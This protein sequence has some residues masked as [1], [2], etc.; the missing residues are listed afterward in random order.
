[1][2]INSNLKSYTKKEKLASHQIKF[3]HKTA[4]SPSIINSYVMISYSICF[5]LTY[6]QNVSE[7]D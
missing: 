7:N 1:M 6:L 5:H 3:K 4:F 2:Y